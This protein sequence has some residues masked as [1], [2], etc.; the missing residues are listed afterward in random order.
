MPEIEHDWLA[1]GSRLACPPFVVLLAY[2]QRHLAY[3]TLIIFA[4][5]QYARVPWA[6]RRVPSLRQPIYAATHE[7]QGAGSTVR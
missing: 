5:L 1:E 3:L 4:R 6:V 7:R 2:A